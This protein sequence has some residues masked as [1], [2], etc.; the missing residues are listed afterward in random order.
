MAKSVNK[1]KASSS[2]RGSFGSHFL[3][4]VTTLVFVLVFG[5]LG[6]RLLNNSQ[7][8]TGTPELRSGVSGGWCLNDEGSN[9]A[10]GSPVNSAKCDGSPGQNWTY[11]GNVLKLAGTYCIQPVGGSITANTAIALDACDGHSSQSWVRD[12]TALEDVNASAGGRANMCLAIPGGATGAQLR[13]E[14]CN[15]GYLSQ[16]W[17]TDTYIPPASGADLCAPSGTTEGA[18]VASVAKCELVLWNGGKVNGQ[19]A[20]HTTLLRAFNAYTYGNPEPWCADFVSYVYKQAG[21]PLTGGTD[22]WDVKAAFDLESVRGFHYP[23]SP[24]KVGDIAIFAGVDDQGHAEIVVST[25]G[26]TFVYGDSGTG[27]MAE[28]QYTGGLYGY[29][30][31]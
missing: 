20:S 28:D 13:L 9:H 16:Q 27:N 6:L 2:G 15:D 26:P 8:A 29:V 3:T 22:G 18:R 17:S 24:P 30:S 12:G 1:K 19:T 14:P 31:P 21:Y 10:Q 23:S 4:S 7:A 11:G 5:F 25:S